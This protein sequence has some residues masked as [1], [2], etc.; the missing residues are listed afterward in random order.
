M[1]GHSTDKAVFLQHR[2]QAEIGTSDRREI[3][4]FRTISGQSEDAPTAALQ[5]VQ[6]LLFVGNGPLR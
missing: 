6:R 1:G 3:P 4:P 2:K 5:F